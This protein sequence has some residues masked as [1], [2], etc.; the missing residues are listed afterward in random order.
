MLLEMNDRS[1]NPKVKD[2]LAIDFDMYVEKVGDR[3][4]LN[5][6]K[7]HV[8]PTQFTSID[9]ARKKMIQIMDERNSLEE[10]ILNG[11]FG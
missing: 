3:F 5:I 9:D 10:M 2:I 8:Y 6:N 4:V 11:R 1:G 7:D